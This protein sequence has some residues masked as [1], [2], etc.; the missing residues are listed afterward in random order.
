MAAILAGSLGVGS[1]SGA[2][3]VPTGAAWRWRPGTNEASAPLGAW[4][5]PGFADRE[6]VTAPA[7]FWFGDPLPG[8]T[9]I[10]GMQGVYGSIFLRRSFV[11][12]APGEIRELRLGALVDDG[13]VAWI[14][15][16]EVLRVRVGGAAGSEVTVGTLAAN[17]P[18][19][20][21]FTTYTLPPPSSY[22][23]AGT[24][25]IAVQ[26]FQ[27]SLG[28]SDLGFDAALET[29][30]A[31]AVAPT[32]RSLDPAPGSTVTRLSAATVTFS[33]PVRGVVAAHL[34]VNG[35]GA[36]SVSWADPTTYLFTFP[37]P[38]YGAVRFDWH[39][40]VTI[41][42]EGEPPNR[43][44]P[45]APG[46]V[47]Q[48]QF[49][50]RSPPTVMGLVPA[51][52]AVV[53][54][55][56]SVSVLFSEGVTGVDA[57]DL[58]VNGTPATRVTQVAPSQYVFEVAQPPSGPVTMAWADGHGI[59][60]G[61]NPVNPFAGGSWSCRLD[62]TAA[63]DPPYLSEFMASNTR[64]LRDDTG[65]YPDWI[66]IYNPSA[67][68]LDLG[69]WYLTDT[70]N[71]VARWRF[72]S[73][74]LPAGGFL[75]V[76]ASG[77]DRRQAGAALHTDFQLSAGGEYLALIRPDGET[78]ASA[79]TPAYPRQLPD[80]SHGVAQIP[81]G[82][83]W[84]AGPSGVYFTQ[85]TPGAPNPGGSAVPGPAFEEVGHVPDVPRDDQDLAVSARVRSTFQPVGD[86]RLAY[87]VMFDPE[88]TMPMADDG[89]HGDGAAGDGVYG[90][91]VPAS[92]AGPGQMVRYRVLAT[93][94]AG[95]ASR[96]PLFPVPTATPEYLG[97]LVE[98]TNAASQLP[99]FHL[100][101]APSQIGRIDTESGGRIS[102]FHDGEFYDNAYMELRGNTSA[103]LSKK[104]H[105]LEFN[106]GH[107]LRHAASPRRTRRS[108]LLAEY[109]D[110][111]Y[112]RQHLS[113]WFL[114]R[115]GVPSP[116]NHPVRVHLNGVFYQLAFHSD[117]IG[118]EQVERMGYDP[119]GALYKAVG[120]LVP[121]FSSTGVFQKL[122]PEGD[123]SRTDYL[124]LANG[125]HE[126]AP[127]ETRRATVFDLLDVPQVIN[128]LAGTRWCAENDD[129]WANMSLYRDTFGDGLWRNIPFDMNASWGQL[130]GGSSPL[131][132]TADFSKSHPLYGGS[133]TE[134]NFNR[135]YDVIVALPETRQMLLRRQ[136]TILDR[137]VQ[138]PGTPMAE[139]I[140]ETYIR[141]MTNRIAAEAALDR[142]KWGFSPW[143]PGKTFAAG[144]GDLLTQF[145]DPRRRHWYV[146]HSITN[147][148]RPI[149]ITSAQNAGI[150]LAQPTNAF[151]EVLAV[152]FNPAS[153][154]QAQE[155][156]ALTNRHPVA[157]DLSGWNLLGAVDFTFKEGTVLP[158]RGVL[159][160]SPDIR[161]FRDRALGPRGGQ[162]LF[163][164]GPY[165]GQLSARGETITLQDRDGRPAASFTY[166]G[167]PSAAQRFL[168]VTEIHFHPAALPGNPT[169]AQAF[170]FVELRNTSTQ[171]VLD[172]A[173]VRFVDGIAFDFTGS[174][175]SRLDPGA[176]VVVVANPV[177]FAAR[178]GPSRSV[179]VAG[180]Y[181]GA[182]DNGGERLRLVDAS[183]E[184]ILDF[185]YRDGWVPAADGN[186]ASLELVNEGL[187]P[188]AW[189]ERTSW[190]A[191]VVAG[192]TPGWAE[193]APRPGEPRIVV[194][195]VGGTVLPGGPLVLSLGVTN[196]AVLPLG[197]E[198]LRGTG[199]GPMS[200][201]S[202]RTIPNRTVF[203]SLAGGD[204]AL[205]WTRFA[206]RVTNAVL[207]SGFTS[208]VVTVA[209]APDTDG[210]GLDD[211]WERVRGGGLAMDP[212]ADPDLDGLNNRGEYAAGTDPADAGS[213]LRLELLGGPP[214]TRLRFTAAPGRT[215]AV[216][217]TEAMGDPGWRTLAEIPASATER[218]VEVEDAGIAR[219]RWYRA[220]TPWMPADGA[221]Q[222][223]KKP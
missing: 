67:A 145:V 137:L 19:P 209:Y 46:S 191:S 110:P 44:D 163:V 99:V 217:F 210:D 69:G 21:S 124:Q 185:E 77:L 166:A 168:R 199:A 162:G 89:A 14:N 72:P 59:A 141:Q 4:R 10:E 120:N 193:D 213:A 105:R 151:P 31:D 169:D 47:W 5:V 104:S 118:R 82:D 57:G 200:V 164:V 75:V 35:V 40:S 93:D 190:R 148:A 196:D 96:W 76:F 130:Y 220:V 198:I 91:I 161:Q 186:G 94:T 23:R 32:L 132:A 85:P 178:Y 30:V 101:V 150:P 187:P 20:V 97:T 17:A 158:S 111:A 65:Q 86:V 1:V 73:T 100:F 129:V 116:F 62:P 109:L 143:A 181:A 49:V 64:T 39:P 84:D 29:R 3:L 108:S 98:P 211:D 113:F 146:T 103:G 212:V 60:D 74:N 133:G 216:Q 176:R 125:I 7:P 188:D 219:A 135:L 215:Y 102:V 88:V 22:L 175:V 173:G 6:F 45:N 112:L 139:R 208:D 171:E 218:R 68:P 41:E 52:G 36:T 154:N 37:Q 106:R 207:P 179:A 12:D 144:V 189:G 184:E 183:G 90:A 55:L 134:G 126:S 153:R 202:F 167:A 8:G 16:T 70:T 142:A 182:L 92:A 51:A 48:V 157:L 81:R 192:G 147:T 24:N 123:P 203:L 50:D 138:P 43:F 205:P 2:T 127:M 107:E 152:E 115:I 42:D 119:G 155:F 201:W 117:V 122:E 15:G 195:P 18:E 54:E 170:E 194:Q 33:E 56:R 131:E 204:M 13:F 38:A 87:R 159:Y 172:L 71:N 149:G 174:A 34:R 180:T 53:R 25:V 27:S 223:L 197:V 61:A 214:S 128:H 206:L 221:S 177:A 156:V 83:G 79:F 11:V 222:V 26:V 58:R 63:D 80:V 140:L 160:V 95:A 66:E 9:R 121:S 114:D 136:R 28:S 78:V 165:S